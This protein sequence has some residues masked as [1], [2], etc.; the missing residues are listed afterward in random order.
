MDSN[1]WCCITCGFLDWTCILENS[2]S[3]CAPGA[4]GP[5]GGDRMRPSV[6]LLASFISPRAGPGCRRDETALLCFHF[7]TSVSS[8]GPFPFWCRLSFHQSNH[9]GIFCFLPAALV[10]RK[11]LTEGPKGLASDSSPQ[12]RCLCWEAGCR[13]LGWS[14]VCPTDTVTSARVLISAESIVHE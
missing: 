12:L 2:I 1:L 11:Q 14:P 7:F 9:K 10:S 13:A 5:S 6:L 4:P 3:F 8:Q